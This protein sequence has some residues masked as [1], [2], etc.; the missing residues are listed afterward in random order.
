MSRPAQHQCMFSYASWWYQFSM[1]PFWC[2]NLIRKEE[3]LVFVLATQR[4][5]QISVTPLG[6]YW[7]K[8]RY[9]CINLEIPDEMRDVLRLGF[10]YCADNSTLVTKA[11]R[12]GQ[13][14]TC[15][16]GYC[17]TSIVTHIH[18]RQWHSGMRLQYHQALFWHVCSPDRGVMANK[19][20][21][22]FSA[23]LFTI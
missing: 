7:Q 18:K 3:T 10:T 16:L 6:V 1:F 8:L 5:G 19:C 11:S 14:M 21:R 22:V 4:Y 12:F 15:D 17:S 2:F 20:S 9:V 13:E 23:W